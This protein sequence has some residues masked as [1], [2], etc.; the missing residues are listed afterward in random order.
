MLNGV[1]PVPDFWTTSLS[2]TLSLETWHSA[3]DPAARGDISLL[4]LYFT[5]TINERGREYPSEQKLHV[6]VVL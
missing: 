5:A 3:R 4:L 6:L 2:K 1:V